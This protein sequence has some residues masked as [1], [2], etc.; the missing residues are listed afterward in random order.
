M[1]KESF[2]SKLKQLEH[3][4]EKL[5]SGEIDLEKSLEEYKKGVA[6]SHELKQRLTE[7]E[8]KVKILKDDA[9]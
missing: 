5:E 2:E 9:L 3:I 7:F 1:P 6:L 4:L 8:N